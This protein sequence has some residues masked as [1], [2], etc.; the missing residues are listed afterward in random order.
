METIEIHRNINVDNV[1]LLQRPPVWYAMADDLIDGG[2]DGP[3]QG[4]VAQC[5]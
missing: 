4:A 3:A 2:A 1:S 5:V